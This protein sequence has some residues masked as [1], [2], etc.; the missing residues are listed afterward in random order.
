M[1][2]KKIKEGG[3][4]LSSKGVQIERSSNSP[5]ARML[6]AKAEKEKLEREWEEDKQRLE[7]MTGEE[8]D[9]AILSRAVERIR[10]KPEADFRWP[11]YPQRKEEKRSYVV[12][13]DGGGN[14][15]KKSKKKLRKSKKKL[16][17]SK[18]RSRRS[19]KKLRRSE[20]NKKTKHTNKRNKKRIQK[21]RGG[22]QSRRAQ[23][24]RVTWAKG[25]EDVQELGGLREA[26]SM[27]SSSST[28]AAL[29]N[30]D[31][32]RAVKGVRLKQYYPYFKKHLSHKL[33]NIKAVKSISKEELQEMAA[34]EG[35]SE[36]PDW[37]IRLDQIIQ[38]L[39][40]IPATPEDAE[41]TSNIASHLMSMGLDDIDAYKCAGNLVKNRI[42]NVSEMELLSKEG[43]KRLAGLNDEQL[44]ILNAFRPPLVEAEEEDREDPLPRED[45]E[46]PQTEVAAQEMPEQEARAQIKAV[47]PEHLDQ[48]R[49][50][51]QHVLNLARDCEKYEQCPRVK[52]VILSQL[53]DLGI[54]PDDLPQLEREAVVR[55][56]VDTYL[57]VKRKNV[58]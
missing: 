39:S 33:T 21:L 18:K 9:S 3:G 5:M 4:E 31:V 36:K 52:R 14:I 7:G 43:L 58:M 28:S 11:D 23:S 42:T 32:V 57:E 22:A 37:P 40:Q 46:I 2:E 49:K 50:N 41:F 30:R 34:K 47:S 24:R 56:L 55:K 20:K 27:P 13:V 45:R 26:E 1:K 44:A 8:K 16:R 12:I 48:I 54:D 19:K 15:Y 25:L 38:G 29:E 6:A 53:S 35:W 10:N 17:K 51:I